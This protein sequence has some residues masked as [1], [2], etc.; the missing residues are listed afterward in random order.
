MDLRPGDVLSYS[1]GSTQTGPL[2][3]RKLKARG[4]IMAALQ[5]RWPDL[6]S[7]LGEGTILFINAYPA[8]IG[9]FSAGITVD[10]YLS[11]RVT[12]RA[13][14]LG[15]LGGHPVILTGQPLFLADALLRH[16]AAGRPL[17]GTL[18]LWVGGYVMPSSLERALRSMLAAQV[19]RL[20]IVQYYGTAEV[21][22]GCLMAR[23]RDAEGELIYYPRGD[24]EPEVVDD[25]EELLL[26]LRSP[27]G[28]PI[29]E[30][31]RTGDRAHRKG[32]G[33]VIHNPERLHPD[34]ERALESWSEQD[35]RRRTGYL[36]RDGAAVRIQLR[37]G[38]APREAA[39]LEHF[40]FARHHGFS[41]LDKPTWR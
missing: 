33:W 22:A 21:D 36:R 37:E 17:P 34:I 40:E 15:R 13:L 16:T 18:M 1:A 3:F 14:Q 6:V 25:G 12:S 30:R 4:N 5:G 35:W 24:V 39:E 29:V 32:D 20:E 31:Y 19:D 9:A 8:A 23:E 11:P 28:E 2:G 27:E 38:E 26:T 7:A 41:W 10:T